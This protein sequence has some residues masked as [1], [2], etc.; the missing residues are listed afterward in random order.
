MTLERR[1]EKCVV[2]SGQGAVKAAVAN[3][4]VLEGQ[5]RN[6]PGWGHSGEFIFHLQ[7]GHP[8][9]TR[10]SSFSGKARNPML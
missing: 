2:Y 9:V 6:G 4:D 3:S 8:S 5:A 7:R 1:R 10:S